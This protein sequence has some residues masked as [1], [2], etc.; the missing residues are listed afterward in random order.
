M[1]I[2][3]RLPI[4]SLRRAALTLSLGWLLG[5][6]TFVP[7][8]AAAATPSPIP[9]S[10]SP[11]VLV[12][13]AH[14]QVLLLLGNSQSMDGNLSGA[15]M[16][17]ASGT[18]P[19]FTGFTPPKQGADTFGN[20]PYTVTINGT[21]YD[22]SASRLNVAKQAIQ[23]TLAT[24][25]KVTD[26]GLMDLGT[27]GTADL[28]TTWVY[29]MS[30][31]GGFTFTSTAGS[32][33]Y[34]NPCYGVSSTTCNRLA[35]H[36]GSGAK[37][38]KY[39][40]AA[41][42]SDS[43][44]VNDVLY[45]G[46]GSVPSVF[47]SYDGPYKGASKVP[48]PYPPTFSLSDYN[49][50][51]VLMGYH[52]AYGS[53]DFPFVTGPT[54]AGYVPFSDEVMFAKRGFGYYNNVTNSGHL[55]VPVA[56]D[57]SVHRSAFTP[58][59]EPET[60]DPDT[61]EIKSNAVNAALA[62]MLKS[63]HSYYTGSSAPPSSNGCT[64][65]RYV[66]LITDGL[67]T[68]DLSGKAWPPLG[69][70]A[71]A[72]Y[73][74][75]A[76][77][78][79]TTG[80]L[81]STNDQALTDAIA[82]ITALKNAK[83][84]TYVVG[85]GAGVDPTKNPTAAATLKAMAVAGGTQNYF[86][87]TTPAQVAADLRVILSQI[88]AANLATTSAA[89][90]SASLITT[91]T[92]YQSRF[93]P[94]D[95]PYKDWTGNV[96]AFP[97]S[98]TGTVSTLPGNAIWD[99][100]GKIDGQ[101][102]DT[103]RH[104]VTW[105]PVSGK[106]VP[107]RWASISSAGSGNQQRLLETSPT[108][109][110]G[111]ARL[112]YLRG[113]PAD[114]QRNGGTFRNRSHILGDI[115]D[116]DPLYVAA[117]NGPYPDAS[118]QAFKKA[119]ANRMPMLYVGA[120]DGMLHALDASNSPSV[121]GRE[122]FAFVPNGVFDHLINLADPTYNSGHRFYVDGSPSEDDVQFADGS[123]HTELVGGLN[124][125]GDS[126]YAL[127]ITDPA[128]MVTESSAASKVL[129]EFTDSDMGRS[130]S[131]PEIA[132]VKKGSGTEFVVVFG[133]GYNNSSQ[134]PYLYFVN[135]ETGALVKKID[136]CQGQP[137]SVCD[138]NKPNGLS[139]PTVVSVNGTGLVSSVY[140]GDLQ[141]NLW[142]VDVSSGTPSTWT[143]SPIFKAEDAGGTPQPITTAP[144]VS[145]HPLYPA[146]RGLMV[147]FGTGQFLG[148]PDITT[149]STQTFY[150]VWDNNWPSPVT[151]ADLVQQTITTGT[152]ATSL[153]VRFLSANPIDW[154]TDKGWYADLPGKGERSITDSRLEQGR[155]IFTTYVPSV[156]KCSGG[157]TS[158]LMVLDF[159]NGSALKRPEIDLN[160]D[161]KLNSADMVAGKVPAGISLG[162][163]YASAPTV[164]KSK[165]GD[166]ND[167]KL[168]NRST[169]TTDSRKERGGFL[170]GR[171]SWRQIQ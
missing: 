37:A 116:S 78:D 16:T 125:G 2:R 18:Y 50:G 47:V 25:Q 89:V 20:S 75:S 79:S 151:R 71:A 8:A 26:F 109:T 43:S 136:L 137:S 112:D 163:G 33:T 68:L 127:D 126:I 27:Q 140:V 133:S 129:W 96:F 102:W 41:Q 19:V 49:N 84:E 4:R 1:M 145:L 168:I 130:Y 101:N 9:L 147:Y 153:K 28:Y 72:G 31:S 61:G 57:S 148:A 17:G 158:W 120:N 144:T 45:D 65:K 35:S 40:V 94:V 39:L 155:V 119:H 100:Q 38:D 83:I 32:D 98:A 24:Y 110:L 22:N 118:Y 108:D 85:L 128:A 170:Q 56:P 69:S 52:H 171:L 169:G 86:P 3:I 51:R 117:P 123:W 54:N 82:Q 159:A 80:V 103:G 29:Y 122:L 132:R 53:R 138:L 167:F 157:G 104:I 42:T 44:S 106:G 91:S 76:S 48:S 11:M 6:S 30:K 93:N 90:N 66:V 160:D 139:S 134:K 95:T 60:N 143:A 152:S 165:Q 36:Y 73:G 23:Q 142:K 162:N 74:V 149:T 146:E 81:L 77:F 12:T 88:Q 150:G 141:G 7:G 5:M 10:D 87:A 97:I 115:V 21:E 63:A 114:E 164:V 92:T 154:S 105:D 111:P 166:T 62:G 14:P 156:G 70:A 67:P 99:A 15:I 46:S 113:D 13:P 59:L 107:F 124:N 161:G 135:A 131:R 121:G 34:P 64:P 55:L 58:L